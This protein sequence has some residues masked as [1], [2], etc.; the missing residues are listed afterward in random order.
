MKTTINYLVILLILFLTGSCQTN[1]SEK[2]LKEAPRD[3]K[4]ASELLIEYFEQSGDFINS[5]AVPTM[6]G[7]DAVKQL[8]GNRSALIV[9]LRRQDDF[10]QGHIPGARH[11]PFADVIDF[12]HKTITP[13]QYEYIVMVCYSG[14]SASYATAILRLLGVHNVYAMK[15]G[16]SSWHKDF[17]QFVWASKIG[18]DLAGQ[19]ETQPNEKANTNDLP[20][21]TSKQRTGYDILLERAQQLLDQGYKPVLVKAKEVFNNPDNY[22]V[23]NYWPE[24]LYNKGHLPSAIRYQ[25]KQSLNRA[26]D[27]L[28]LPTDKPVVT[29]CFTGQHAA[30]VTAYLRLLGYDAYS[31]AYGA[32]SF[33]NG[34]LRANQWHPFVPGKSEFNYDYVSG[35]ETVLSVGQSSSGNSKEEKEKAVAV[36][37]GC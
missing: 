32:N 37:S 34:T 27:L 30:F 19:L 18:N 24:K 28:T 25:P 31:I 5:S 33:M 22:Y 3:D 23:M 11:V 20:E 13:A 15:F 12:F 4:N 36:S 10:E 6:I 14:Q 8:V 7:A 35:G 1:V 9:D 16:M 29:Y 21:I 17:S 26:N 2:Q